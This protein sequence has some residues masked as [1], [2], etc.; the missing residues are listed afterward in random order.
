M[1]VRARTLDAPLMV[2]PG[3]PL[4]G[5]TTPGALGLFSELSRLGGEQGPAQRAQGAG[6]AACHRARDRIGGA[7]GSGPQNAL[8]QPARRPH[9][10]SGDALAGQA[11]ARE[12]RLPGAGDATQ[13]PPAF[14]LLDL[15]LRRRGRLMLLGMREAPRQRGQILPT[16]TDHS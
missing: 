13:P 8:T 15:A 11:P 2:P 5:R 3:T 7:R 4:A 1:G 12:G 6:E 14:Q 9:L 16:R 10:G